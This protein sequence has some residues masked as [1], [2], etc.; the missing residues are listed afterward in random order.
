MVGISMR[1][2]VSPCAISGGRGKEWSATGTLAIVAVCQILVSACSGSRMIGNPDSAVDGIEEAGADNFSDSTVADVVDDSDTTVEMAEDTLAEV[3]HDLDGDGYYDISCGGDDCDDGDPGVHPYAE[4]VCL[5]GVDQDCDGVIDG[6][7]FLDATLQVA[8]I[9]YYQ[10]FDIGAKDDGFGMVWAT[11]QVGN[12]EL[13]FRYFELDSSTLLDATRLDDGHFL[14]APAVDWSGDRWGIGYLFNDTTTSGLE[15]VVF[16]GI[17]DTGAIVTPR[18]TVSA[19]E[20]WVPNIGWAGTFFGIVYHDD[21]MQVVAVGEDGG[22][23]AGPSDFGSPEEELMSPA[24]L[25]WTGSLLGISWDGPSIFDVTG[26]HYTIRFMLVDPVSWSL[27][28]IVHA[29]RQEAVDGPIIQ[30][31]MV[32]NGSDFG[33]TWVL[34]RSVGG[35]YYTRLDEA[36][37]QLQ[38]PMIVEPH[39]MQAHIVWTGS[40]YGMTW[41]RIEEKQCF[42][43]TMDTSGMFTSAVVDLTPA[44]MFCESRLAWSGSEFGLLWRTQIASG[45]VLYFNRI[46]FCD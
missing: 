1:D 43:A 13:F 8:Q 15:S 35:V 3:C 33:I 36:G 40:E 7:T 10:G 20:G 37:T 39:G 2:A 32:W 17:D 28:P 11:A 16:L 22:V 41:N 19:G 14:Q 31:S 24:S 38:P 12:T 45:T 34:R 44:A 4:E 42:F 29:V 9:N 23:V 25:A 46:G 6:P 18:T 30:P 5:D 27:G 21:L 26:E